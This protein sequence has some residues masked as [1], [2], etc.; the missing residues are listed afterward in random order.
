[1]N[2]QKL[3]NIPLKREAENC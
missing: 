1:M 3:G 2:V